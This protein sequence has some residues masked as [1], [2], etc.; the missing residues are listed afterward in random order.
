[1]SILWLLTQLWRCNIPIYQALQRAQLAA[2]RAYVRAY[3]VKVIYQH[4]AEA[5]FEVFARP[6]V[7]TKSRVEDIKT[8]KEETIRGFEIYE[9]NAIDGEGVF[10]P[11]N[12]ITIGDM[13]KFGDYDFRI[14]SYLDVAG[15]QKTFQLNT[16]RCQVVNPGGKAT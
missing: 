3:R 4:R 10:P 14:D 11:K 12:G 2:S 13:I 7:A 9:Q 1:M 5:P 16:T 6:M 8:G 15:L